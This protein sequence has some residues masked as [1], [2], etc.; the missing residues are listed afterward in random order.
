MGD[1]EHDDVCV[2]QGRGGADGVGG[3]EQ[4][5]GRCDIERRAVRLRARSD[6]DG[7]GP[8]SDTD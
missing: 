7:C 6:G 8:L 4:Q 1:I 2:A 5:R 3:G